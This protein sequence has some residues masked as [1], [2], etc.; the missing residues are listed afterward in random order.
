MKS[1]FGMIF[2]EMSLEKWLANIVTVFCYEIWRE[3]FDASLI[4]FHYLD[5]ILYTVYNPTRLQL[6]HVQYVSTYCM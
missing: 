2:I 6:E 5:V 4:N 3:Q 1:C